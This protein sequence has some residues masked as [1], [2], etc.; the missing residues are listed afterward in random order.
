M[1]VTEEEFR[2]RVRE[3]ADE[4]GIELTDAHWEQI[5]AYTP[6]VIGLL[7]EFSDRLEQLGNRNAGDGWL[8]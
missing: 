3:R 7:D 5:D 6:E 4:K 8:D 1:T 2:S